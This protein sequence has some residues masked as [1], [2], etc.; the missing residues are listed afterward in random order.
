[1]PAEPIYLY[2]DPMRLAQVFGNLL[3]NSCKYTKPGGRIW[4]T[5][6]RMNGEVQVT[7]RDTGVGIPS[8][9]L[10]KVFDLFT[11]VH[12]SRELS[13]GGL[14]IGLSLVKWLVEKHDGSVTARSD[15]PGAGSE[16]VVRLPLVAADA[17]TEPRVG[18]MPGTT[19]G[20]AQK[21]LIVDDNQDNAESLNLLLRLSGN[22][23]Q[24]AGD[25]VEAVEKAEEFLPDVILLDIGLPR[26]NGYETC[27][28]IR[29]KPWGK[30]VIMVA[31]TGWG[32][33]EDRRK[34]KEAGFNGHM[35]K[36]VNHEDLLET[37]AV[38]SER[39]GR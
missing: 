5:A 12:R 18:R 39:A 20:T 15:G 9:M 3:N 16:F 11:Q 25:G 21:I 29:Q 37:L 28:T 27:R 8:D 6:E 17:K 2:A 7:I 1:L 22:D 10:P 13:E 35:V 36:P 33:D 38:L 4:V 24:T 32:Q 14:G 34:A 31:L 23:T 30:D 26:M 19:P